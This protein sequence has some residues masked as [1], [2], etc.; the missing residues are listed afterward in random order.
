[1]APYSM[2]CRK[3][4]IGEKGPATTLAREYLPAANSTGLGTPA[5]L[6]KLTTR[7]RP[8]SFSAWPCSPPLPFEGAHGFPE[9]D[10]SIRSG[11]KMPSPA[12]WPISSL[13]CGNIPN[14]KNRLVAGWQGGQAYPASRVQIPSGEGQSWGR[15]PEGVQ[16]HRTSHTRKG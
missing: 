9:T 13:S 4:R 2:R 14:T 11:T 3:R 6:V 10:V 5:T 15:K 1:M 16:D 7:S 12:A 8:V